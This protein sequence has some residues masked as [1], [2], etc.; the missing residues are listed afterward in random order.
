MQKPSKFSYPNICLASLQK[1]IKI[2]AT[3]CTQPL[4]LHPWEKIHGFN[5][6]RLK[7]KTRF[8]F[9]WTGLIGTGRY[10]TRIVRELKE[11]VEMRCKITNACSFRFAIFLIKSL[12][13]CM[14]IFVSRNEAKCAKKTFYI[15][16]QFKK[17]FF[18]SVHI[19]AKKTG[20][21]SQKKS[22]LFPYF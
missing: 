6:F 8:V 4:L 15:L 3:F 22:T 1:F 7:F 20:T 19:D 2:F 18:A 14:R 9:N 17:S 11:M 10:R 13:F 12:S 16:H 5:N 21:T